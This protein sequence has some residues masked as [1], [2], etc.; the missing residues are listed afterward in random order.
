MR[1][2]LLELSVLPALLSPTLALA[3]EQDATPASVLQVERLASVPDAEA[4]EVLQRV[5]AWSARALPPSARVETVDGVV[6][7]SLDV[8][9]ALDVPPASRALDGALR[10]QLVVTPLDGGAHALVERLTHGA[11][12]GAHAV[13][14]GVL[15]D[16]AD[17]GP[18]VCGDVVRRSAAC[19]RG[20][21]A[22][23]AVSTCDPAWRVEA[24]DA[25]RT[26]A[27]TLA[28]DLLD[29]WERAL[30]PPTP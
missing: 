25:A 9:L 30:V 14:L 7:A 21:A 26:A 28:R 2:H 17:P 29:G 1:R 24:W 23:C 13:S 18:A 27:T 10:V 22:L 19:Q 5:L 6:L 4:E 16:A 11:D 20:H 15:S 8:P 3:A 12:G